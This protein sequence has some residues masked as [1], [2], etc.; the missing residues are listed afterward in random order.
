MARE[1]D[2]DED[3]EDET[4]PPDRRHVTR[5]RQLSTVVL[6]SSRSFLDVDLNAAADDVVVP[7]EK[8]CIMFDG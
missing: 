4:S 6:F 5:S 8:A 7:I 1:N 2:G 3:D